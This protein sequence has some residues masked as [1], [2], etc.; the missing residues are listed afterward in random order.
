MTEQEWK[1]ATH[2]SLM[3]NPFLLGR[4]S[5]RKLRLFQ[6]ACC[7]LHDDGPAPAGVDGLL[8]LAEQCADGLVDLAAVQDRLVD[9]ADPLAT[10][11]EERVGLWPYLTLGWPDPFFVACYASPE[12]RAVTAAALLRCIVG[13]PFPR[14]LAAPRGIGQAVLSVLAKLAGGSPHQPAPPDGNPLPEVAF[15]PTWRTEAVVGLSQGIYDDRGFGRLPVLADAL[16]DA[17]CADADIL[18]HCRG[19]GPHARGC[20]VV[21]AVLGLK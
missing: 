13:N 16:E 18:S 3:L 5:V 21:D 12:G 11:V 4:L 2:P 6:V 1:S 9:P 7:R 17:G 20:W 14:P 10:P 8:D 19:E 15:E